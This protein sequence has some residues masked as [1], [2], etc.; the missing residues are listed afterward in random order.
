MDKVREA[1]A[2]HRPSELVFTNLSEEQEKALREVF[3]SD[4]TAG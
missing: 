1:F 4:T 3:E 2:D